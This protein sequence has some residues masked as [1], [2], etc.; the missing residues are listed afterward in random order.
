M[1]FSINVTDAP[2]NATGDGVTD[3]SAAIQNAINHV[4]K[5]PGQNSIIHFPAGRYLLKSPI[6]IENANSVQLVGEGSFGGTT[7]LYGGAEVHDVVTFNNCQH[8]SLQCMNIQ[9]AHDNTATNGNAVTLD[10]NCY[11]VLLFDVR[12]DYCYNG[13]WIKAATETRLSKVQFRSM[14]GTYGVRFGGPSGCYRAVLDDIIANNPYPLDYPATASIGPWAP[15]KEY[16]LGDIVDS[17][18][19]IYQCSKAG[20]SSTG[21]GPSGNGGGLRTPTPIADGGAEWNFVSNS[22]TW[23]VQE[24]NGYSLVINKA[25]LINGYI[26]YRMTS[27]L[28]PANPPMWVMAC[29]MECDHSYYANLRLDGGQGAYITTSWFGS[30]LT[31]NAV[32]ILPPF[33]GQ[34]SLTNS[35]I[36]FAAQHG[37]L[38][39]EY[40]N[41]SLPADILLQSNF[42]GGNSQQKQCQFNGIVSVADGLTVNGNRIGAD[43]AA[44]SARTQHAGVYIM[45]GSSNT[46]VTSNNLRTN[47]VP[48]WPD[49]QD[50]MVVMGNLA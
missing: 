22:I 42:I 39:G 41:P 27:T 26:G 32:N 8:S 47:Q 1:K 33:L 3:D 15:G 7:L 17:N 29:D 25:A 36:S 50:G 28:A 13:V 44:P 19:C 11:Q 38:I 49:Q 20:R 34:V 18:G 9:Y 24:S 35:R 23:I 6:I 21:A 31:G 16:V 43:I 30:C 40:G 4:C 46:I 5:Q 14:L 45:P 12:M 48:V 37:V 10:G 2:F